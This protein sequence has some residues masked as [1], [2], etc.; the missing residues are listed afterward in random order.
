M[1]CSAEDTDGITTIEGQTKKVKN[2]S[3]SPFFFFSTLFRG[4]SHTRVVH[5]E[6]KEMSKACREKEGN[7]ENLPTQTMLCS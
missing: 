4:L 3:G 5:E 2:G 1:M 6:R 7:A